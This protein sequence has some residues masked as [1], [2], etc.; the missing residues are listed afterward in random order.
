MIRWHL[1]QALPDDGPPQLGSSASSAEHSG[2]E[3]L[4]WLEGVMAEGSRE[5]RERGNSVQKVSQGSWVSLA[6]PGRF[7]AVQQASPSD[8]LCAAESRFLGRVKEGH[9]T[10]D[11]E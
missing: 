9:Y 7:C 11:G 2:S 10:E 8:Q 6:N 3:L 5:W 4:G 1:C